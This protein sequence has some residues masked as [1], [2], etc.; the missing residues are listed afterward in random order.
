M[1]WV[2]FPG[3][4]LLYYDENVLLGMAKVIGKPIH[5]DQNTLRVDRGRFA[6]VC[7]EI[8][9]SNPIIGKIWMRDHWYR[10]EYEGLHLLCAHYVCY[11]HLAYAC[12]KNTENSPSVP[13]P[14]LML[15]FRY[16]PLK[17][18]L[19]NPKKGKW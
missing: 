15:L 16:H 12:T 2:R 10:V 5:I 18:L 4:N 19:S 8:Y 14:C 9:L 17:L 13:P 11:G 7:V 6:R 3:L 1:V